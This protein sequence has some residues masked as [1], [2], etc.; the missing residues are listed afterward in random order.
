MLR[1]GHEN[2]G[3]VAETS[4]GAV[5][6]L[7]IQSCKIVI[8]YIGLCLRKSASTAFTQHERSW[9]V[10]LALVCTAVGSVSCSS[11]CPEGQVTVIVHRWRPGPGKAIGPITLDPADAAPVVE[12][13]THLL[14]RS[15]TMPNSKVPSMPIELKPVRGDRKDIWLHFRF[16]EVEKRW[17]WFSESE[18]AVLR[19]AVEEG[20]SRTQ[21]GSGV[22]S[23]EV[24]E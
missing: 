9:R 2:R 5:R 22:S 7:A 4:A 17:Y 14:R 10:L 11:D 12:A 18:W 3:S 6:F 1:P 20:L 16:I 23:D 24:R 21:G 15:P 8:G 13:L 19:Q